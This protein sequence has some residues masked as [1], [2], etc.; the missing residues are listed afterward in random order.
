MLFITYELH[1]VHETMKNR[2]RFEFL[3]T[4]QITLSWVIIS[5][6]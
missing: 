5:D 4:V 2:I 6:F 3:C 1:N